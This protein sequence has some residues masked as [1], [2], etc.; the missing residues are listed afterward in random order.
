MADLPQEDHAF[1]CF[2]QW[3]LDYLASSLP[4]LPDFPNFIRFKD[5][6][7][8]RTQQINIQIDERKAPK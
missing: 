1:S 8:G 7:E 2:T 3:I 5:S 6:F 4:L